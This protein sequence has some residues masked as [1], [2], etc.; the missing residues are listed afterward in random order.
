VS[1]LRV[2]SLVP[3]LSETL[4]AWGVEPVAVTRF[5]EQPGLATVG[6]TKNPDLDAIVALRPDLVLLDRE[7]NRRPDAEA[8]EAAGLTLHVTHVRSVGDVGPALAGLRTALGLGPE[9]GGKGVP[10]PV[11]TVA[12]RIGLRVFVPIWPRPWMSVNGQTYGSSVLEAAGAANVLADHPDAYPAVE[13]AEVADLAPDVVLA[14]SE[15]YRFTARH[16]RLFADVAPMVLVDGQDLFWWG[17]RT[18]GAVG[19]IRAVLEAVAR[20]RS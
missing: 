11:G 17:V 4:V 12:G 20:D 5:C 7:E 2:V 9:E 14:P 3:S 8:L 19:R 18:T 15:P 1:A 13:L 16:A 10:G 6:G